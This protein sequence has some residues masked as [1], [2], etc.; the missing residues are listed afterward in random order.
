MKLGEIDYLRRRLI[1]SPS[2]MRI[3][4]KTWIFYYWPIFYHLRFFLIQTLF[5]WKIYDLYSL[6]DSLHHYNTLIIINICSNISTQAQTNGSLWAMD[7]STFRKIVLKS[8]FQKR[9]MYESFLENVSLLKHL[10]VIDIA[11]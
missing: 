3:G 9:K 4:Y 1:F 11:M 6:L 7:R 8:A 2:F 5:K 10:E